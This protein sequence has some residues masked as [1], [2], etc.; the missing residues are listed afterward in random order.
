M[1]VLE[2]ERLRVGEVVEHRVA[3]RVRDVVTVP[4]TDIEG[5]RDWEGQVV[6]DWDTVTLVDTLGLGQLDA[7]GLEVVEWVAEGDKVEEGHTDTVEVEDKER[8]VDLVTLMVFL[9]GVGVDIREVERQ[10]VGL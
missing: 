4:D 8:L 2:V 3:E 5:D 6:E 10:V 7:L 1:G 9:I